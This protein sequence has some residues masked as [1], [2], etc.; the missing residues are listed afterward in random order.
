MFYGEREREAVTRRE[1]MHR[2]RVKERD[3]LNKEQ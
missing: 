2:K 1:T 3:I